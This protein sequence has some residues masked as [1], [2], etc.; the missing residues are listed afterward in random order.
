MNKQLKD[1]NVR[2]LELLGFASHE[3]MQP[4][5]VLKGY[6]MLMQARPPLV[7]WMM[8]SSQKRYRPCSGMLIPLLE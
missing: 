4:I 8:I 2:Y 5:G 7:H 3:L 6:L 1:L